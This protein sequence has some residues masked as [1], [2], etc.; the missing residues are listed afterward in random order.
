MSIR[1]L[2]VDD[3]AL[4][5][6]VLGEIL[7]EA[8]DIT[9]VG[10]A[11][12]PY[13]A[14]HKIKTLE[15]DVLTLDVEMPRMDGLKFLGHL[16]RLHP[17]P[18]VMV[19]TL[20]RAGAEAT[21]SALALGAFDFLPK[22]SVHTAEGLREYAQTLRAKVRAAA[23]SRP[24]RIAVPC[25][26][27][28]ASL[29][30]TRAAGRLIALG[31]STGG[32]EAL[33]AVL[34]S[35]PA[36]TPPVV[37]AQHIPPAFSAAFA[38]RLHASSAL[39]V[40]EASEG[41]ALLAGHAYLAPGGTHLRVAREAGGWICRLGGDAPVNRHRPSVDVLFESVALAAGRAAVGAL[42]TGMGSDGARGLLAM[43]EAGASTFAQDEASSIVWGM[44]GS[45]VRLG[46]V[47]GVLPLDAIA[48]R[49]LLA[50]ST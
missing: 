42:L 28:P 1:V 30:G 23:A 45:A 39:R 36:Q 27:L 50:A 35:F 44:P 26:P 47:Q 13:I 2:V 6:Q 38:R 21:M 16:M 48:E 18:V 43:R 33:R 49:I 25:V 4:V 41:E 40:L 3:S 10:T 8:D 17:M 20:T 31:A 9:V 34:A 32:T 14:R 29:L 5:R 24:A 15:P 37:L 12:D 11:A 46:A 22:P 7:N 19:S